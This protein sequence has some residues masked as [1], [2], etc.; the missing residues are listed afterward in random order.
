VTAEAGDESLRLFLDTGAGGTVIDKGRIKKAGG[1][2]VGKAEVSGLGGVEKGELHALRALR[3][4]DYDVRATHPVLYA[5]TADLS[6]MNKARA[7]DKK[8]PLDG[9]LGHADLRNGS[10]L[11][12]L[13]SNTLYLRPLKKTLLPKLQ[14]KW[15]ATRWESEGQSGRYAPG[16]GPVAEFTADRHTFAVGK[17]KDERGYQVI[18]DGRS[19]VLGLYDPK[20]KETDGDFAWES[21]FFFRLD[22]GKL[23]MLR[24]NTNMPKGP[25]AD[26]AATKGSGLL[27]LEFEK[28]K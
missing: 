18:D 25:P 1:Q 10:A 4:G 12:D 6:G 15:V 8:K 16:D 3:I 23:R 2:L 7:D 17:D 24:Y 21:H 9:I 22:D 11:I 14:G 28:A 19:F 26:F 20:K 5:T 13:H 27:L